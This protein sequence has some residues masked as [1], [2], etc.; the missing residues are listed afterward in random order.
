MADLAPLSV[1]FLM[2]QI[3][4]KWMP[5]YRSMALR[6]VHRIKHVVD[7]EGGLTI[8][9]TS[10]NAIVIAV[11]APV[12][13]SPTQVET[14]SKVYGVYLKVEVSHT[15]G[16]GRPNCYL[17]VM[18][19]PGNNLTVVDPTAVGIDDNKRFVIHQEM[20]MMS[21]DAGNGLPRVLFNG[22]I[23]IPKGMS[24]FGPNDRLV[25]LLQSKTVTG[26]F[27]LQAHYKEFR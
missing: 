7:S 19:N 16:T 17:A 14:A 18:K 25:V 5:R 4:Q 2:T 26:D 15:S 3:I 23:K 27:C 8:G 6:P 22:V 24:R 20:V 12:L 21:G 10:V 1:T 13:G 11:D 9:A